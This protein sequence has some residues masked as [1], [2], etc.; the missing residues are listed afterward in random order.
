LRG[1][2]G[3]AYVETMRVFLAILCWI[4]AGAGL[5]FADAPEAP[6]YA[7]DVR[8]IVEA[9]C[10][11]CHVPG[12]V[13]PMALRTYEEV[14]PWAK[15]IK[16]AVA[17]R[18]M[19]PFHA[20][21]PVGRYVDDPR[22]SEA[23]IETI[24]K[25]V[26]L[27]CPPG[28][29]EATATDDAAAQDESEVTAWPLGPPDL[30]LETRPYEVKAR[31]L[32]D[33]TLHIIDHVF[34]EEIWIGAVDFQFTQ[35]DAVHHTQLHES[36]ADEAL[37]ARLKRKGVDHVP[38]DLWGGKSP[39]KPEQLGG[40]LP[41]QAATFLAPGEVVKVEAGAR[42]AVMNH[43][44]P[45]SEGE[46]VVC[47]TR[48]AIYYFTG[49]IDEERGLS[50]PPYE[51]PIRIEPGQTD[52]RLEYEEVLERDVLIDNFTLHMHYRGKSNEVTLIYPDGRSEVVFD[53]P[54]YDF[55]WQRR[56]YLKERIPVPAGTRIR[57]VGTWDN[58]AANPRNPDPSALVTLGFGTRQEMW[59]SALRFVYPE[60]LDQPIRI[61]NGRRVETETMETS[62]RLTD[63][64]ERG[65]M[66]DH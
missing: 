38:F 16:A 27:N 10:L 57:H 34:P 24:V 65:I 17:S 58:S 22:L 32:D 5:L 11:N 35:P 6:N 33:Y 49:V 45:V 13:A 1:L 43:Y 37:M 30:V 20:A 29:L 7:A 56:Y 26:D 59:S 8:P 66:A 44:A 31:D 14:R 46:R 19:P 52:F 51:Q 4:L 47:A 36:T 9:R 53:V 41:G 2:A 42:L 61:V 12:Q 60:P 63:A 25:W 15:S 23:E 3:A 28:P 18:E 40:W 64:A 39:I 62:A 48:V 50:R 21:G 55:N 54:T